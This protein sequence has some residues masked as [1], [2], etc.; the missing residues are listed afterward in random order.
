MGVQRNKELIMLM[1]MD[2]FTLWLKQ[3]L[4]SFWDFII[5][6]QGRSSSG[7][8]GIISFCV[9]SLLVLHISWHGYRPVLIKLP[10]A[11]W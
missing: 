3:V 1:E 8:P 2:S 9:K 6:C 7:N 10:Q 4:P 5:L 11:G